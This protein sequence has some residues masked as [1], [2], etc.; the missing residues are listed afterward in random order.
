MDLNGM[1]IKM[2]KNKNSFLL[3]I[4]NTNV[5]LVVAVIALSVFSPSLSVFAESEKAHAST[6]LTEDSMLKAYSLEQLDAAANIL[7]IAADQGPDTKSDLSCGLPLKEALLFILPLKSLIDQQKAK[8]EKELFAA[9]QTPKT[10][11]KNVGGCEQRCHCT[12]YASVFEARADQGKA[13]SAEDKKTLEALTKKAVQQTPEQAKL[14]ARAETW[15]C[16]SS[17]FTYLKQEVDLI[18]PPEDEAPK[19]KAAPKDGVTDSSGPSLFDK[20]S[21]QYQNQNSN[22]IKD[23]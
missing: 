9:R 18:R 2:S 15:F 10:R 11:A 20:V 17:L 8:K 23:H 21:N 4:M 12:A 16:K 22:L 7:A 6:T 3:K 13:L 14:C 19:A 5:K 1:E